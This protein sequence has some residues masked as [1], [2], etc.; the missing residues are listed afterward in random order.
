MVERL[1]SLA[2]A[3]GLKLSHGPSGSDVY[4]SGDTFYLQVALESNGRVKEVRVSNNS[5]MTVRI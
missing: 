5:E 2:S 1:E 4:L 3:H